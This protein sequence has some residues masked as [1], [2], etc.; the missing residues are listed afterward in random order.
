V[1]NSQVIPYVIK[2]VEQASQA[3]AGIVTTWMPT[4]MGLPPGTSP[5]TLLE[6]M[7][8][9]PGAAEMQ[10]GAV[11]KAREVA[12]DV[13]GNML[14]FKI[15]DVRVAQPGIYP[16]LK[17]REIK[18]WLKH[19]GVVEG[20]DAQ[21]RFDEFLTQARLPWVRTDMAFIPCP[22]F[23][24]VGFNTTTDVFLTPATGHTVIAQ[25][26][27]APS[28]GA[29]QSAE[30]YSRNANDIKAALVKKKD[31]LAGDSNLI[32]EQTIQVERGMGG[33][34]TVIT[35][36]SPPGVSFASNE[37]AIKAWIVNMFN[38][39]GGSKL[40]DGDVNVDKSQDERTVKITIDRDIATLANQAEKVQ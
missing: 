22:P 18:Q 33:N 32:N 4:A 17:P 23:T 19:D 21:A 8:I 39:S 20:P 28:P 24:V 16:I 3:A 1:D 38:A 35:I 25:N 27:V 2:R 26:T 30:R 5:A 7:G 37:K 29:N 6:L 12:K 14:L 11:A 10:A 15:A 13:L 40:G 31:T 34:Q 36:Q 9:Q